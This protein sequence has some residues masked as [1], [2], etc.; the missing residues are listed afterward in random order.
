[1][2]A[3]IAARVRKERGVAEVS[4]ADLESYVA[5]MEREGRA[6][7]LMAALSTSDNVSV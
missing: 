4:Q 7:E 5:D 2:R 1:M 6:K 3:S